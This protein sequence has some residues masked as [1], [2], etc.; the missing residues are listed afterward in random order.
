MN[1]IIHWDEFDCQWW[2]WAIDHVLVQSQSVIVIV[3]NNNIHYTF[4]KKQ[5]YVI[6]VD[7][8]AIGDIWNDL[9]CSSAT[10]VVTLSES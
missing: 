10:G 5:N 7:A 4:K 3:Y 2:I 8:A 9:F 6:C 1:V